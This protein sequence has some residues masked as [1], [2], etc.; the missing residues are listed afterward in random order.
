MKLVRVTW[1]D[2][3]GI[4]QWTDIDGAAEPDHVETIGYLVRDTPDHITIAAT[5]SDDQF[6]AGM[7]IP[8]RMLVGDPV[9][10][11]EPAE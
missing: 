8:R 1:K 2:A 9:E 11:K 3:V 7:Q 4:G 5:V 6:N 10:I